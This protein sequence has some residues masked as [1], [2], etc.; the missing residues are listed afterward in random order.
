M[1]WHKINF[2]KTAIPVLE[3]PSR[4]KSCI[5]ESGTIKLNDFQG[6]TSRLLI[7]N[8]DGRVD[9]G[10][11]YRIT[12]PN[13]IPGPPDP[14]T[15]KGNNIDSMDFIGTSNYQPLNFQTNGFHRMTISPI[16]NVGI[17]LLNPTEK[18][19]LATGTIKLRA[20]EGTTKRYLV[21]NPDGR[22]DVGETVETT[23]TTPTN[24]G[25]KPLNP[26][27][28]GNTGGNPINSTWSLNGNSIN[29]N[30]YLGTTNNFPLNFH[31]N[32]ANRMTILSNGNVGIGLFNPVEKFEVQGNIKATGT[33]TANSIN[34]TGNTSFAQL[35]VTDKLKVGNTIWLN[36]NVNVPGGTN[37][38]D[39]ILTTKERLVFAV[40]DNS[41]NANFN[42]HIKIGIGTNNPQKALHIRTVHQMA[43]PKSHQGI[44]LEE[45]V[46]DIFNG[47]TIW[48]IEPVVKSG[49]KILRF[50]TP[51]EKEILI[52]TSESKI[53]IGTDDP[54]QKLH[55]HSGNLLLSGPNSS[56]LFGNGE[57]DA[58][59][60]W[61]NWGIE[62]LS[63]NK[64]GDN[65]AGL[66]F[67]K[68]YGG[69]SG[70]HANFLMHLANDGNVGIGTGKPE[71]RLHVNGTGHFG[72]NV[73]VAGVLQACKVEVEAYSW[74]DYVFEKD[75]KLMPIDEFANYI[76][77]NKHLPG[78]PSEEE[79]I[80]TGIDVVEMFK[81][82]QKIIEE[83]GLYI[84]LLNERIKILENRK[85]E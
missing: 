37:N 63:A 74:C 70:V 23:A 20:F 18:L 82:Q 26:G 19:D 9:T 52:M 12:D 48:D 6:T 76:E 55:L 34:V 44:R 16:G 85:N 75:Y 24:P 66:N 61:G 25:N 35:H 53:G 39:E 72:G 33:V 5:L 49:R 54:K 2:L 42:E 67:W 59:V 40:S 27:N 32:G 60:G 8:P 45:H 81:M 64:V 38:Y 57:V 62:Y 7:V 10:G 71:A 79:L 28:T 4:K 73:E 47:H 46:T 65:T 17:G 11:V 68:P 56:I 77:L 31:T 29:S 50:G 21:I 78:M 30:Q 1:C 15:I 41:G 3:Q 80:K 36:G 13:I 84:K 43:G 22:I 69:A 14:W 58:T 83:Y 51:D